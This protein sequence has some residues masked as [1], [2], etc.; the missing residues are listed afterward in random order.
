MKVDLELFSLLLVV[1]VLAVILHS[2]GVK[3]PNL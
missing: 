2:M 3:C 1:A